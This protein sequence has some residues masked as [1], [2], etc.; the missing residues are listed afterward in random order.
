MSAKPRN[1]HPLPFSQ[2][3]SGLQRPLLI[4]GPCSAESESQ[5]M[6]AAHGLAAQGKAR[7][8]RAGL[9]KPRTRPGHFEGA[10]T[11]ALPWL[12][13]VKAETGL[14]T[15]T[16][17]ATA[18]HV[19]AALDAGIDMLWIGARTTPNPFSVQE[20]ADAL[21]GVDIPVFVKNPINP[22]LQLWIGALERLEHAGLKRLAAIHRGFSWFERTPYRN[23]PMWEFPIRLKA[24]FPELEIVCDPSHIAGDRNKLGAVAQQALD[25]GLSGLMLEVHPDPANACSD[26][27]QQVTPEAYGELIDS[28]IFRQAH[29]TAPMRDQLEELRDLIDQLDEEIAQKLGTRMD[30]AERI[31]DHKREHQVAILQPERWERIMHRQLRLAGHLGLSEAFVKE[32]MDAIHRE[33]I[34]RQTAAQGDADETEGSQAS[35]VNG[36]GG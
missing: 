24:A 10:G 8:F 19:Q 1:L 2:W 3:G 5:V 30:I 34:R 21:R 20:I 18:E 12:Q 13:R 17:V 29:P 7:V 23:S 35:R 28:L 16:E 36:A 27:E 4:A 26:A 31:G 11:A 25:L 33:S 9:W 32:F 6:A 22:D 15:M 14:L